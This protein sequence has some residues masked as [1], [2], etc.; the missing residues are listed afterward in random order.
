MPAYQ[1]IVRANRQV[2]PQ[3]NQTLQE[4]FRK[5]VEKTAKKYGCTV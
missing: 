2:G 5:S 4:N 3:I 1:F